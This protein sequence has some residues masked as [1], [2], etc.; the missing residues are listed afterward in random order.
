MG[1]KWEQ[2]APFFDGEVCKL[3]LSNHLQISLYKVV[4]FSDFASVSATHCR[5]ALQINSSRAEPLNSQPIQS[6]S[7]EFLCTPPTS[8]MNSS[9]CAL[10]ASRS[11]KS[12]NNSM[13][14]NLPWAA[15]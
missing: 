12:L 14:P 11:A 6:P 8:N 4:P 2:N 3:P 10:A 9:P 13:S 1:P 7:T 5:P 15:G